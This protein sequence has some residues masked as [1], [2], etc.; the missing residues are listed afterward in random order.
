MQ[1]LFLFWQSLVTLHTEFIQV[2]FFLNDY[3]LTKLDFF[4]QG[5][6]STFHFSLERK[7]QNKHISGPPYGLVVK[8][9]VFWL[10]GLGLVP[11][12]GPTP[13]TSS[14]AVL[15]THVRNRGR[16]ARMLGQGKSSSAK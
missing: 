9:G 12:H 4:L 15:V 14:H 7:T 5:K 8:I 6:H 1:Y 3:K 11:E 2:S 13:L 16:P 10:S